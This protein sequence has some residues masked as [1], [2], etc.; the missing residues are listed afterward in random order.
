MPATKDPSQKPTF[1]YTNLHHLFK[2]GREAAKAA[3]VPP[4][5]P[6]SGR[7]LKAEDLKKIPASH[8][9]IGFLSKRVLAAAAQPVRPAPQSAINDLK[10]NLNRLQ[11]LQGRLRFM[12]Q[13]LEDLVVDRGDGTSGDRS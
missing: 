8:E 7:V 9:P 5:V 11:D 1:V 10:G 13:E 2:K 12:L 6:V 4:P 3:P